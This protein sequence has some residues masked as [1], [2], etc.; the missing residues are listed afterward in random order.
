LLQGEQKDIDRLDRHNLMLLEDVSAHH[1]RTAK[2][3]IAGAI[4]VLA[5]VL[6]ATRVVPLPIAFLAG[7]VAMV[8]TR[9][10]TEAEA[11]AAIEWRLIVLIGCMMAF[12]VAMQQTGAAHWLAGHV[13]TYVGPLG[14]YAVM[15]AFG[16]LTILLTQPMSNQAAAL[17]VLPV[18][19]E[20]AN[21]L[22]LD[23]RSLVIAVTMAASLSFLTPLE[24]AC[25]LVYGPGRYRFFDFIRVGFPL[26]LMTLAISMAMVPL[27]WPLAA[28]HEGKGES[29]LPT[30]A[31]TAIPAK[32]AAGTDR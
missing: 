15:C 17:V 9:C 32:E 23:P 12:G 19:V 10:L 29:S 18:A 27:L 16:V 1:P 20:A 30:P 31:S 7:V 22:G 25:L 8:L 2:G 4:F 11:Y 6:G 13:V 26:T 14:G 3:R 21:Q 5:L 28:T 24:P